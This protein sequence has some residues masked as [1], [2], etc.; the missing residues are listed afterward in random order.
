MYTVLPFSVVTGGAA[1]AAV[2][3]LLERVDSRI[4]YAAMLIMVAIPMEYGYR[5]GVVH[6]RATR[7]MSAANAAGASPRKINDLAVSL[8]ALIPN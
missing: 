1:A 8:P 6:S 4:P 7:T 2:P 3:K 5:I